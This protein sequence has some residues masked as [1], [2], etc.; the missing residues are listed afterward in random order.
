MAANGHHQGVRLA[1]EDRAV[2]AA[3]K[4]S[5]LVFGDASRHS[6]YSEFGVADHAFILCGIQ[7]GLDCC[8]WVVP[9]GACSGA[10]CTP[11]IVG[12]EGPGHS[13]RGT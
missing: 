10:G 11:I 12:M 1:G 8:D 4:G 13:G 9:G 3:E 2:A 7:C 6:T 5:A